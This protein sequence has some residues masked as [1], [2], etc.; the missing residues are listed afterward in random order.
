MG[1]NAKAKDI[2][3]VP[4]SN[5]PDAV[6]R[7]LNCGTLSECDHITSNKCYKIT[8]LRKNTPFKSVVVPFIIQ[9][10]SKRQDKKNNSEQQKW[11]R[12]NPV[13]NPALRIFQCM[14]R[15]RSYKESL[16][17]PTAGGGESIGPERRNALL[18]A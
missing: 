16:A 15:R 8:S 10:N 9:T 1:K 6:H 5:P 7:H 18:E 2:I 13:F 3:E 17:S 11:G 12:Y 4:N 14:L